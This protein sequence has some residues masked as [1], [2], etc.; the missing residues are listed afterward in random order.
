MGA[1][2]FAPQG[3]GE[4]SNKLLNDL[5]KKGLKKLLENYTGKQKGG[6]VPTKKGA[7]QTDNVEGVNV[8][9]ITD[10]KPVQRI[11][12]A[13]K[14]TGLLGQGKNAIVKSET[15]ALPPGGPRLPGN[16]NIGGGKGGGFVNIPG[17]S[18]PATPLNA[19]AFFKQAQQGVGTAGEYLS[20][21]QRKSLFAKSKQMRADENGP[22]ISRDSGVDIVS[23]VNKVT[24]AIVKLSEE[25]KSTGS[26]NTKLLNRIGSS[27]DKGNTDKKKQI[28][29]SLSP[30]NHRKKQ[31][32][33]QQQLARTIQTETPFVRQR[34]SFQSSGGGLPVSDI[35]D[36]YKSLRS[37]GKS[38]TTLGSKNSNLARGL[39]AKT[40]P[41]G[42]AAGGLAGDVAQRGL[43]ALS[44]PAQ[45]AGAK[46]IEKGLVKGAEKIGLKKIPGV[47]LLAG[48]GFGIERLLRGDLLGAVGEIASGAASTVPGI[49]TGIS[50]GIDAALM[51]KDTLQPEAAFAT[52]G[53][54]NQPTTALMGEGGKA[55]GVFPLEGSE[56]KKTFENFGKGL[57][58]AQKQNPD[59]S[60]R[61][62]AK[63]LTEFFDKQRG[64]QRLVDLM[65]EAGIGSG[66][67][68][69]GEQQ[70]PGQGEDYQ[71]TGDEQ[72]MTEAL[73]AGEEG[74]R[75]DAY[76]NSGDVPTIGYGQTRLDGRAVK[77]G[78]KITKEQA[79][80][81]LRSN[82]SSHRNVAIK[83]VGADQWAKLDPKAKA[84]L[85]SLA[86]N[87]GHV[88]SVAL[89]AAK[90]GD[91]A[92][93][94]DAVESLSV[95]G[96]QGYDSRL[97]GRRKREAEFIRTGTS[98]R[99][100]KDFLAGG[101]L[102]APSSGPMLGAGA[103]GSGGGTA[104]A[105]SNAAQSLKGM[106]TS[107]GPDGG[108]NA[109]VWSVNQVYKKAGIRPPWGDALR[110][111]NAEAAMKR[112][113][114]FQV[115]ENQ[116]QPGDIYIARD[117]HATEPQT[118]IGVVVPGGDILSNSSSKAKFA[119]QG[120]PSQYE[121]EYG[122][123]GV[124][125]RM[126]GM[127]GR[128]ARVAG[129][130]G[131]RGGAALPPAGASPSSAQ[132]LASANRSNGQALAASSAQYTAMGLTT[133]GGGNNIYNIAGGSPGGGYSGGSN[134]YPTGVS[135]TAVS[136]WWTQVLPARL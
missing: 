74:V 43:T 84:V 15:R 121:A 25:T 125:Y 64:F 104:T 78:D 132:A 111:S 42:G 134:Q 83:Q 16:P 54:I 130:P 88:P 110:V 31:E 95:S 90:T 126:P 81:G 89:T 73:I 113:G 1:F 120:P 59:L 62:D 26:D 65:K 12:G 116:R 20:P 77:L 17:I 92:K 2:T 96:T 44:K 24:E 30:E 51:A 40:V 19:D 75:L 103:S 48:A 118:H 34:P 98:S 124:F 105:L 86:Y 60:A 67:G 79:V 91:T 101:K 39:S 117:N 76:Q 18:A 56:G 57:L 14:N 3:H 102:A 63:G 136:P 22:E 33:R 58:D 11:L 8:T 112:D 106:D 47:G 123:K 69:G 135:A 21:E 68:G 28:A 7:M 36:T 115:P 29:G 127:A 82:I 100:D 23:A 55:E 87:Y 41:L 93:I 61:N 5:V 128:D 70:P 35:F 109:C 129:K 108:N 13:G 6:L 53:I 10:K 32:Q 27:I 85:T 122:R 4:A 80:G 49:G 131:S 50:L 38:T 66:G 97:I 119:W 45:K 94:A 9:D 46:G 99:L 52:G 114:Y 71:A 133:G 72:Q 37:G 107:R